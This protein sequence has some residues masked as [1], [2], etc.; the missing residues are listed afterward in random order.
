MISVDELFVRPRKIIA[1]I[2]MRRVGK[3]YAVYQLIKQL[4]ARVSPSRIF[5]L[6]FEDERIPRDK[7]VLLDFTSIMRVKVR[8]LEDAFIFLDEISE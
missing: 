6:N 8:K 1:I 5:Y 2:G 7:A 4:L 3:T